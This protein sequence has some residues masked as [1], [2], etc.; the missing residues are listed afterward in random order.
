MKKIFLVSL[1][2]SLMLV[3]CSS[4]SKKSE[5]SSSAQQT[6][7]INAQETQKKVE[8]VAKKTSVDT[9]EKSVMDKTKELSNKAAEAVK[10][11]AKKVV[12]KTKELAKQAG[13]NEMVQKIAKKVEEGTNAL[14]G[15]A[16]AGLTTKAKSPSADNVKELFAKCAG[17]HGQKAEKKALGMSKIIVNLSSK[18]IENALNGY[19]KGTFGG[20]M[21]SIMQGQVHS[22]S[23]KDIKELAD[24]IPT[25]K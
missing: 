18:E 21:K 4:G 10:E 19:K 23:E 5:E 15:M 12:E 6:T 14:A 13:D 24:Y 16:P 20:A 9:K 3:G 1:F 7:K 22:L 17:C 2:L 25:L 11:S 8:P